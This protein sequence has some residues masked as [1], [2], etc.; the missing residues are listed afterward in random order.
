M[1]LTGLLDT[2]ASLEPLQS[3]RRPGRHRAYGLMRAARPAVSAAVLPDRGLIVTAH[4]Q[5]A[6]DW[7]Q[8]MAGWGRRAELFPAIESLPY[9]R[10]HVDRAVLAQRQAVVDA[11]V[12]GENLIV[13]APVR[14]LLQPVQDRGR[15]VDPLALRVG[16]D[17]D[18]APAVGRLVEAGYA[19]T[20][21]VEEPGTFARRGGVID[22]YPAGETLPLRIELFG[23]EIESLRTFDPA[24]QR[25]IE[26]LN[27]IMIRPVAS[28][29]E[30]ARL[31]ALDRL[32]DL[33]TDSLTAEAL[34]R[35]QDDLARLESGAPLDDLT[36]FAPYLY[37]R[38]SL[39]DRMDPG[40]VVILDDPEDVRATAD[41]V[42]QQATEIVAA[43]Q[44]AGELPPGLMD[45]L[46]TAAHV[47]ERLAAQPSISWISGSPDDTGAVDL[48]GVFVPAPLYHG[49][50]RNF[51]SDLGEHRERRTVIISQQAARVEELLTE[52][53]TPAAIVAA[54]PDAPPPGS[55]I[56]PGGLPEGWWLPS[57]HLM[58]LSDHEIFGRA[59]VRH[60]PRRRS[61]RASFFADF[62]PGDYVVHMEHGI[63][64]FDGVTRMTVDGAEREYAL[65]Q[66]HG[67]DRVYVPTDQLE[68]L[69]RYVGV[70][71][72][73]PQLNRLGGGEW[74]RARQRAKKAAEDIARELVDLYARRAARPGHAFGA[75]SPWQGELEA[76]F[77]YPETPDQSRAVD[78]VK[79]DM[80]EPRPMDRLV[81]ADVG[82]GKTEVAVRAAFKAV[83]DGKQVAVLVPTTILAQQHFETFK[84]RLAPFPVRVEVL[85]RFRNDAEQR[86]IVTRLASGE[87]DV[88][89]G[90][91][92]LLQ[93][94]VHFKNLGL[95]VIDEEQR[96]GVKHK[97]RLKQLRENVDVL[98]L[99]ATP[100]PRTLHMTLVGIREVS[101]IE[102]APEGRLPIKTYLQPFDERHIREAII[103]ELER[104]GQVYFVHNKV[105][106]IDA[107]ASRIRQL[108][109]EARVLVGHG[110]MDEAQLETVMT[111]FAHHQAD[112]LIAS[113]IIENGLD[114]PDANTI[115]V[116]NAHTLG[117]TQL[118]QLRGR[119]GRSANQAYAYLLYPRDAHL[120]HDAARR[121]EA[122]FESQELGAGFSIAMKDLEIRGAGNLLGAEQSGQASAIGFDLYTRMVSDAVERLRGV[123]VEEPPSVTIDLPLTRF[124]PADY[125][126]SEAQRLILYR[127]LASVGDDA[128]LDALVDEMEDRFGRLPVEVENLVTSVR[129]KLLAIAAK[130]N[131]VTLNGDLLLVKTEPSGL[132]DRV[133]LYRAYGMD[134]RI[135]NNALRIPRSRLGPDWVGEI[136]RILSDMAA[137][138]STIT[139]GP[140]EPAAAPA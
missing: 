75:D 81:T 136:Q 112:V 89:I 73:P 111:S 102:T 17:L 72:K 28:F 55:T 19:E 84:E 40:T 25:S 10:A 30:D 125:V 48:S 123:V 121:L 18:M 77:P 96:F 24:T 109:P 88:V 126:G 79:A 49:R 2:V 35:W 59:R 69:T 104:D 139:A 67:A 110:Q 5:A 103:R 83:M 34:S 120:S 46:V 93:K 86:Q 38:D 91:H 15:A 6:V 134:A 82:Y 115:I 45:P 140:R 87:I 31:D 118:Y 37:S 132:F 57:E 127:R 122:V 11:V 50:L 114:I 27:D 22:V 43:R 80:E 1:I 62:Q 51:V 54:L 124:L 13:V 138:R 14:A 56:L 135:Q 128:A 78:E 61:A 32:I 101:V 23:P 98:T 106:T 20:A 4:P 95:L 53:E 41:S 29:H 113:T 130:V 107:M 116:N 133:S 9:E 33:P 7:S 16:D 44:E 99:T 119:V 64:R 131:T 58:I 8:E 97:E 3:L 71:E 92:R 70:G 68:R 137:L 21:V 63:G 105:A 36:V 108:V 129:I 65:I 12:R 94:D 117:L 85:S 66:Y 52:N 60:V 26:R 76:S 42:W 47:H 39:L 90:T 74:Q 100:I